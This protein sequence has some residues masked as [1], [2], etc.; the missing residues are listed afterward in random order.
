M[1]R[2]QQDPIVVVGM[3]PAGLMAAIEFA[4][5][6]KQRV[7]M[8]EK[9]DHFTRGQK[10]MLNT[11]N[12]KYLEGIARGAAKQPGYTK[13][14][15]ENDQAFLQELSFGGFIEVSLIQ[16]FLKRKIEILYPELV[17]MQQGNGAS[18]KEVDVEKGTLRYS[19]ASGVEQQ[20]GYQHIIAADGVRRET[21]QLLARGGT[22]IARKRPIRVQLVEKAH[23]TV[24]LDLKEGV[25]PRLPKTSE[26]LASMLRLKEEDLPK[27]RG[28]GWNAAQMPRVYIWPDSSFRKYYIAGE[29]PERILSLPPDQKQ[30]AMEEW[31]Q[32]LMELTMGYPKNEIG[33]DL[34]VDAKQPEKSAQA[35]QLKTTAFQSP[36]SYM[37]EAAMS[38]GA[39]SSFVVLGDA[40]RTPNFYGGHGAN[41]AFADARKLAGCYENGVIDREQFNEYHSSKIE[42]IVEI[43]TSKHEETFNTL[44]SVY[45]KHR[46]EVLDLLQ[47]LSSQVRMALPNDSELAGDIQ[48]LQGRLEQNDL[49]GSEVDDFFNLCDKS[50]QKLRKAQ[51]QH[52]END[53]KVKTKVGMALDQ[54]L[55]KMTEKISA[56]SKIREKWYATKFGQLVQQHKSFDEKNKR[57]VDEI[58]KLES[59]A[60][61][62]LMTMEY[63]HKSREQ[64][65]KAKRTPPPLP[66]K[67]PPKNK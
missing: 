62:K 52:Q 53:K 27:L 47:Q 24:T 31:G 3:G 57:Q 66:K 23:G 16:E 21:A 7:L 13:E 22:E 11:A 61:G 5:K 12:I 48:S 51:E 60:G 19:D 56:F 38:L 67:P 58:T 43:T 2:K 49:N 18:I 33:L 28:L 15:A 14:D 29:I 63:T 55:D 8:L 30:K 10:V 54:F 64:Y 20:V 50:I 40:A 45:E 44:D 65:Q 59:K 41:D 9:R 35:N 46:K 6:H 4:R 26:E 32:K 25:Q 37:E 39:D 36:L 1:L 42:R 17:D 34:S